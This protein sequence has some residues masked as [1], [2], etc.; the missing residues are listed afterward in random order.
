MFEK[1]SL[2]GSSQ[3]SE[4]EADPDEVEVN[5]DLLGTGEPF[6]VFTQPP[7][8]T[9]PRK[10]PLDDP[11]SGD[12]VEPR[13]MVEIGQ[14]IRRIALEAPI[15]RVNDLQGPAV[16]LGHPADQGASVSV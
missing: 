12:E 4:E 14:R 7:L 11:A 15:S 6:V 5:E 2:L 9:R 16:R 13:P 1:L 8:P 3:A 10:G